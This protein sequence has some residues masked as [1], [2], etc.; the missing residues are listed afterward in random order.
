M[1][2]RQRLHPAAFLVHALGGLREVLLPAVVILLV[3][4]GGIST[5]AVVGI[6]AVAASAA[7]GWL[8]WRSTEYWV[9]G[10][11]LH[12]VSGVLSPDEKTIPIAR[13]AA[14]DEVAGPVQ[15]IFGV[16][17]LHVQTA[18]GGAHG[19]IV[20][21]A[22]TREAAEALRELLARGAA[23]PEEQGPAWRL[24]W[25]RLA[26][27]AVT[28][29]QLGAA[30]PVIG[31]IAGL[32]PQ[33]DERALVDRLPDTAA[34]WET[35]AAAAAGG[36]L[37]L[38]LAGTVVAFGGFTV[39]RDAR[40]LRLQRGVL[41]RRVASVRVERVHAVRIVE[42]L[43]RRPLG[44]CAIRMELA[45]YAKE[46]SAAQTLVPLCRRDEAE[47]LIERLMPELAPSHGPLQRPPRRAVRR[48][49]LPPALAGS[50]AAA[51]V[52]TL[53]AAIGGTDRAWP[54]IA[55]GSILGALV[56]AARARAAGWRFAESVIVV[57]RHEISARVTTVALAARVQDF[58]LAQTLLQRRA[59][60]G[61]FSLAVSS[62]RRT[63]VA[64]AAEP[65]ARAA[66]GRLWRQG[67]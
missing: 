4:R 57:R 7:I 55:I 63:G 1:T 60:L 27:A 12:F 47:R 35:L 9:D 20:L 61:A 42:G 46:P 39:H 3:N 53:V 54:A 15:R 51:V 43:L 22:V 66:V 62:G 32:A 30:L 8:R 14:V 17:A 48:Y 29:P 19:E 23:A 44:L 24:S 26:I 45:G 52:V 16:V 50:V 11:A 6:L 33:I 10:A 25:P 5:S 34:G 21:S 49:V 38:A 67:P 18:G 58:G 13:V 64:H 28:G 65:D 36:V 59:G 37:V 31:G 40:R 2:S 56:G 41:F